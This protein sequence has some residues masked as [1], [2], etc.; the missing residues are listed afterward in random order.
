MDFSLRVEFYAKLW[1]MSRG[2]ACHPGLFRNFTLKGK[3]VDDGWVDD[4]N[5]VF[6]PTALRLRPLSAFWSDIQ[7]LND[8][9]N[10]FTCAPKFDNSACWA[11]HLSNTVRKFD[12]RYVFRYPHKLRLR[13]S[14]FTLRVWKRGATANSVRLPVHE[15][16]LYARRIRGTTRNV[17]VSIGMWW[18]KKPRPTGHFCASTTGQINKV[19]LC[20]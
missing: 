17:S 6:Y 12:R 14:V 2:A 7:E 16:P 4:G 15:T 9:Y 13:R 18:T 20:P 1:T 10:L 11:I 5:A 3:R 8:R 19:R